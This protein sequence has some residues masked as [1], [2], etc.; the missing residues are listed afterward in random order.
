MPTIVL[1]FGRPS[2][3]VKSMVALGIC[4]FLI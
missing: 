1:F 2:F 3:S 4:T